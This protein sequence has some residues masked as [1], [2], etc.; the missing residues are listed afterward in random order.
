MKTFV[1]RVNAPAK[2]DLDVHISGKSISGPCRIWSNILSRSD[3]SFI[4]RYKL[5]NTC[6]NLKIDLRF[7][8]MPING[9]PKIFD[10]TVYSDDCNCPEDL[11]VWLK[12]MKCEKKSQI[13]KDLNTFNKVKFSEIKPK[14]IEKFTSQ[15]SISLC[16]YVLKK[17]EIYRQC[18][19]EYVDFKIFM[20]AIL[21]SLTR[22][23]HLPDFEMFVNLGDWPI[24]KKNSNPLP[25][26]SWC[27]SDG[28]ADITIPT[29]D[30][31][32]ATLEC[33]GR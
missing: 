2:G 13:Y 29:Y 27:G 7:N 8:N 10:D 6:D 1:F 16:H 28:T 31:T 20:D 18:Y 23:V 15:G 14:I 32:E 17:N 12:S 4:V 22:K 11:N 9:F 25:I 21:L 3:G 24:E 5:Y 19:G 30:L 33:M 26:F